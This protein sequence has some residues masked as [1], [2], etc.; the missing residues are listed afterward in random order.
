M[1]IKVLGAMLLSSVLF[2]G[3]QKSE[4]APA[5]GDA[6]VEQAVTEQAGEA[7]QSM[8]VTLPEPAPA[9]EEAA[10]AAEEAAPAEGSSVE[11]AAD[12]MQGHV[13]EMKE[14]IEQKIEEVKE[15]ATG[16]H[17]E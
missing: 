9:A 3:C 11:K 16:A 2:V 1:N 8:D 14:S 4:T 12:A 5:E 15:D 17:S 10:P 13:D 7:T 6:A